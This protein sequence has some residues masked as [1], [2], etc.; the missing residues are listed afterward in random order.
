M[1]HRKQILSGLLALTLSCGVG[2]AA[3]PAAEPMAE[4]TAQPLTAAAPAP[5]LSDVAGSAWYADAVNWCLENDIMSGVSD[6]A[7]A[8]STDMVRITVAD[9]LYRTEGRP[10]ASYNG[11]FSDVATDSDYAS[12]AAWASANDI[13]AEIAKLDIGHSEIVDIRSVSTAKWLNGWKIHV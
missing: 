1:K 8:P 9:A 5:S 7:F 13:M 4:P 2:C 10:E 3:V 6:T 12:A 11:E